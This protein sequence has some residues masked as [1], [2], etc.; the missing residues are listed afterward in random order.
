LIQGVGPYRLRLSVSPADQADFRSANS[1]ISQIPIDGIDIGGEVAFL[2][3]DLY[4]RQ[5]WNGDPLTV[6]AV[7]TDLDPSSGKDPNTTYTWTITRRTNQCPT[8]I[9]EYD[10]SPDDFDPA[11]KYYTYQVGPMG[12]TGQYAGTIINESF[13]PIVAYNFS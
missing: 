4:L 11:T 7:V 5:S 3:T 9:I 2:P 1:G 10:H 8:E 6:T 13:G 12:G